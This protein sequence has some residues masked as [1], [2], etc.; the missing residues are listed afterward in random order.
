VFAYL[1]KEGV[2]GSLHLFSCSILLTKHLGTYH[3]LD[4]SL[5]AGLHDT[6]V[7]VHVLFDLGLVL[8]RVVTLQFGLCSC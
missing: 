2:L 6:E 3:E 7:P 8:A 4:E 1:L 5:N